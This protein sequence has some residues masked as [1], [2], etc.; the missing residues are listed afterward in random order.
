MP[1]TPWNALQKKSSEA[2]PRAPNINM[3][4]V[5]T[6]EPTAPKTSHKRLDLGG[7][8]FEHVLITY[9]M[10]PCGLYLKIT[11]PKIQ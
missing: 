4:A 8:L 6:V 9:C 10:Y 2:P 3:D 5:A 11:I 7:S 1:L